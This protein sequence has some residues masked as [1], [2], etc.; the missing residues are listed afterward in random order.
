MD[1]L[2]PSEQHRKTLPCPGCRRKFAQQEDL[3]KHMKSKGHEAKKV[4]R[5]RRSGKEG[6][7][8]R[9]ENPA[10]QKPPLR[11]PTD[12][13]DTTTTTT[14]TMML[15][16]ATETMSKRAVGPVGPV[17][18]GGLFFESR[19]RFKSNGDQY[20]VP[21]SSWA[22]T[23]LDGDQC[24]A[25]A[26]DW[27][28]TIVTHSTHVELSSV[29]R[30]QTL[31][32]EEECGFTPRRYSDP[33]LNMQTPTYVPSRPVVHDQVQ[34]HWQPCNK[35]QSP[36]SFKDPFASLNPFAVNFVHPTLQTRGNSPSNGQ[37]F[38]HG[39]P[40]ARL[41]QPRPRDPIFRGILQPQDTPNSS[42]TLERASSSRTPS[43]VSNNDQ[44]V[45]W[46]GNSPV[47]KPQSQGNQPDTLAAT[48]QKPTQETV[49]CEKPI[50]WTLLDPTE[51]NRTWKALSSKPHTDAV[52]LKA[53]YRLAPYSSGEIT[54]YRRCKT[55]N[56]KFC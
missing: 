25:Q 34:L 18:E 23:T 51:Y 38:N 15:G 20:S 11:P 52:L 35:M 53:H 4:K 5:R 19:K 24:Q 30:C 37:N 1:N 54:E 31:A 39:P 56:R 40:A 16:P 55:C 27:K 32:Q 21:A 8:P 36:P 44:P 14:T 28:M 45:I 47:L 10:L 29:N 12:S 49:P 48:K 22:M 50:V 26:P 3:Q 6:N 33:V 9:G 46:P 13:Q 43:P 2:Q 42:P 17:A 41:E 7:G